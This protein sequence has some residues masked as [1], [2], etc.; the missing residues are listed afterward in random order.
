VRKVCHS[1]GTLHNAFS[2]IAPN[3]PSMGC[4]CCRPAQQQQMTDREPGQ[5]RRENEA[6][7]IATAPSRYPPVGLKMGRVVFR[8]LSTR[9]SYRNNI[10]TRVS[11]WVPHDVRDQA[12]DFVG[13]WSEKTEISVG[14]F[15]SIQPDIKTIGKCGNRCRACRVRSQP[16]SPGTTKSVTSILGF[17]LCASSN[18]SAFLALAD[19]NTS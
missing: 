6:G 15:I 2:A 3:E 9:R 19:P 1:Y 4:F 13:R 17:A 14:R 10:P 18:K 5:Q 11:A 8:G 16:P 12:V 7:G